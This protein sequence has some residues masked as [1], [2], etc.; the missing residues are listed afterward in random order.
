MYNV[1]LVG[2]G[3]SYL[4]GCDCKWI[5]GCNSYRCTSKTGQ[6]LFSCH[7]KSFD[8]VNRDLLF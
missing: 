5:Q 7:I 1:T 8:A 4:F 3:I 6:A 2:V